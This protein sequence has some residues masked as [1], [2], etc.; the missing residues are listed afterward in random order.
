MHLIQ[1]V[2]AIGKSLVV[3]DEEENYCLLFVSRFAVDESYGSVLHLGS[4]HRLRVNIVELFDLESGLAS[5]AHA[6]TLAEHEDRLRLFEVEF[7][8]EFLA[9]FFVVEDGLLH[10]GRHIL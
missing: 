2:H 5:Y 4:P 10:V 7:L 3:Q 1:S 6:L 8:G 9:V